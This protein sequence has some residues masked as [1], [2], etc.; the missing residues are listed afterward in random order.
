VL[1]KLANDAAFVAMFVEEARV[2]SELQHPNIVQVHDFDQDEEG[3]YFLVMEWVDGINL[4]QWVSS[5][6]STRHTRPA[7][8]GAPQQVEN[9]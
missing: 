4:E 1:Q 2:V 5:C 6:D 3:R 8:G 7:A 9:V